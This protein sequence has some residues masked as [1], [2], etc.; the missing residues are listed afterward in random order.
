MRQRAGY[1]CDVFGGVF[2]GRAVRGDRLGLECDV[3]A[4]LCSDGLDVAPLVSYI[5]ISACFGGFPSSTVTPH[6]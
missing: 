4:C 2:A 3:G 5:L 6:E 1:T